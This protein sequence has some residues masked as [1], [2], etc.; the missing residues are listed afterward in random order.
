MV[1]V[2]VKQAAIPILARLLHTFFWFKRHFSPCSTLT[3]G[4]P[5]PGALTHSPLVCL[6]HQL[7]LIVNISTL[8]FFFFFLCYHAHSSSSLLP[9]LSKYSAL[10]CLC[11]QLH[12]QMPDLPGMDYLS[13]TALPRGGS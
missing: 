11:G 7:A 10:N 9:T 3:P 13:E 2:E 1:M 12:W 6:S 5:L 8:F 4:M